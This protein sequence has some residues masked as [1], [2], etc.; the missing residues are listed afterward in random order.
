MEVGDQNIVALILLKFTLKCSWHII[1]ILRS[2]CTEVICKKGVY[3]NFAKFI[4]K[5]L[6]LSP[7]FNKVAGQL[8]K[9]TPAQCFL[10]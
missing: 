8:K 5:Q 9:E 3:K 7:F 1:A 6:Y 4:E 2:S 10:R